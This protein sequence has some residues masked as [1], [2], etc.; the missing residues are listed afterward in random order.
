MVKSR[1]MP[2]LPR[3]HPAPIF[4]WF[5]AASALG[6][7]PADDLFRIT[8]A[9]SAATLVVEG[10]RDQARGVLASPLFDRLRGASAI[11]QWANSPGIGRI[12]ESTRQVETALGLPITTIRDRI[13]GD[14]AVLAF[15]PG[16][17][18]SPRESRGLL[19]TRGHDRDVVEKLF[20]GID[21]A[22]IRS[23]EVLRIERR[24]RGSI[25]YAV[26]VYRPGTKPDECHAHLDGETFAWSNSEALLQDVIDLKLA[27]GRG[28]GD[29]EAFGKVRR[30]LPGRAA[31]SLFLAPEMIRRFLAEGP[32]P[33]K[34]S[35][36]LVDLIL[37][38]YAG[39]IAYVG[40]G[41]EW[42]EGPSIQV[43]ESLNV[44][45]LQPSVRRWLAGP[46]AP[47]DIAEVPE[48]AWAVAA[49]NIDL[50]AVRQIAWDGIDPTDLP[51]LENLRE[52]AR[53]ILSGLDPVDDLL[54]RLNPGILAYADARSRTDRRPLLPLVGVVGWSD[55]PGQPALAGSI[56]NALKTCLALRALGLADRPNREGLR[57]QPLVVA[58]KKL[59]VLTNGRR[60][61]TAYRV[62]AG[63]LAF[64]N[65][66]EAV[67]RFGPGQV[68][69]AIHEIRAKHCGAA[70]TFA[71][72]DLD[73]LI[74][75][76]KRSRAAIA[77]RLAAGSSRPVAEVE[78]DLDHLLG[79]AGL[80]RAS[81]FASEV[82]AGGSEVHRTLRLL[83]R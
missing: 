14:A 35:G 47:T 27:G 52:A 41:L 19:L 7:G 16:P 43:H 42:G 46:S 50:P 67:A 65:S 76:V 13:L 20:E 64:G 36:R 56:D 66:A 79:L 78:R 37:R 3:R 49:V 30:G 48:T 22:Q 55:G 70:T 74:G 71:I 54:P 83:A 53:G 68:R 11:Q 18:G 29:D 6:A 40:V 25:A 61:L 44:E 2:L 28:L 69:S 10:L 26:R 75:E 34:W 21:R 23:G 73:R 12:R 57:V 5:L 39:A 77:R 17:I 38:H 9:H 33:S 8:P 51:R 32:P 15:F 60:N 24:T 58:A 59:T 63:R 31:A 82:S 81:V 72:V 45:K 62:D 80:F 4:G 1:R